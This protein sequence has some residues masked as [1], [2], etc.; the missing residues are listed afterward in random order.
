M[1]KPLGFKY[2]SLL[3][4]A[5]Y[6]HKVFWIR[7]RVHVNYLPVNN[8]YTSLTPLQGYQK[9]SKVKCLTQIS[10]CSIGEW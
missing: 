9:E 10:G 2:L 4:H 3:F 7:D 6:A 1:P 8:K 5:E